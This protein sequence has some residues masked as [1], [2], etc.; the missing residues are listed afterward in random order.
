[1]NFTKYGTKNKNENENKQHTNTNTA[2]NT[3]NIQ[4][5]TH[6]TPNKKERTGR[7]KRKIGEKNAY[8]RK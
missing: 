2:N 1:L 8:C 5:P 4:H 3:L 6:S 7:E